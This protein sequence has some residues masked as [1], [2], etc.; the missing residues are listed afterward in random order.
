[1]SFLFAGT[2]IRKPFLFYLHTKFQLNWF[3]T[4]RSE[5][6]MTGLQYF[7]FLIVWIIFRLYL[8]YDYY[9]LRA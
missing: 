8:E 4:F 1:M 9:S 5:R 2:P 6:A 7:E 3:R